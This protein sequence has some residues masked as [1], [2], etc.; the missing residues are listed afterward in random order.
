MG[1]GSCVEKILL[2]EEMMGLLKKVG[3]SKDCRRHEKNF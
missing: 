1:V 2:V 3:L